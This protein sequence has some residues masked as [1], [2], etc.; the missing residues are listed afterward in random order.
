MSESNG[1][2]TKSEV[3]RHLG[4]S[5]ATVNRWVEE[6]GMPSVKPDTARGGAR[7]FLLAD[8]DE[9]MREHGAAA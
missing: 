7:R 5:V 3:A 9:W 2:V 8:V 6:K 1:W 4:V